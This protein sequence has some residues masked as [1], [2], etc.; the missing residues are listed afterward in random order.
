VVIANKIGAVLQ[1]VNMINESANQS[2]NGKSDNLPL[3]SKHDCDTGHENH[4]SVSYMYY[5]DVMNIF[6]ISAQLNIN[7]SGW[8]GI[9]TYTQRPLR[10]N[11]I[12]GF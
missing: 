3:L 11:Y 4:F 1:S 10:G 2:E 7:P 9:I 6:Q 5:G 12:L 8:W